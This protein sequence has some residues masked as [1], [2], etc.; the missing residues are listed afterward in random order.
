MEILKLFWAF[1]QIGLFSF[2]G[3]YAA[4]PLIEEQVTR[5]NAWLT[6]GELTDLITISQMTPGPIAINSASFIGARIAGVGGAVVAT[7][8]CILPSLIIVVSFALLYKKF[9]SLRLVDAALRFLRPAVVG[10]IAASALTIIRA[11]WFVAESPAGG[12][13][14][15]CSVVLFI[16]CLYFLRFYRANPIKVMCFSGITGYAVYSALAGEFIPLLSVLTV[17]CIC[18]EAA[19]ALKNS[20]KAKVCGALLKKL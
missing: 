8:G 13:V 1:L 20:E 19:A 4:L 10:M 2:G 17:L 12:N 15:F 11:S 7:L 5:E 6:V 16:I 18:C 14:D 3:G 9:G